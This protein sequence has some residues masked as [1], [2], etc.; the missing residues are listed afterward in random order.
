M[1]IA[2]LK[3]GPVMY[4]PVKKECAVGAGTLMVPHLKKF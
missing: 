4:Q 2:W 3:T 1:L